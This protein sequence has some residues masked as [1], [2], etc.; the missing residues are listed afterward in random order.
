MY[1]NNNNRR[2][3]D[4][5]DF[6]AE[7]DRQAAMQSP[8]SSREV[9]STKH[10]AP[11]RQTKQRSR[12]SR[13]GEAASKRDA[14]ASKKMK[15]PISRVSRKKSG[16][17][18]GGGRSGPTNKKYTIYNTALFGALAVIMAIG[19]YVGVIFAVAPRVDTDDIYSMLS[20]R[21]I[22]YDS[23]GNEIENLYFDDG[24]RTVI[25][26]K[27]IPENMVNAVV[28][29]EDKKFWK[30]NGFNFIRMG[31]AVIESVFGGGQIS[32]TSTVTQQ[33]ARN[34]YLA[35]IKSQRSIS[36]KLS[37]MY[38]T[39]V[40]EKNLSKEEIMEAYLNTIYLGFNSYG[41][42]SAAQSYF[43][44][45][46]KDLDLL[47]CASL[48]ALPK[49]PDTYALV[50]Y[51]T[52]GSD[53]A[54]PVLKTDGSTS[55]VYNGELSKERRD[56]VLNIMEDEGFI[57]KEEHETALADDLQKHMKVSI[58]S[59]SS[60]TS[61]FTDFAI[62]QLI[63]DLVE[64]YG[65]SEAE[66]Q[67]MVYTG[68]LRIYTTMD[69]KMQQIVK[70]EFDEDR[71]FPDILY[72]RTNSSGDL[73]NHD[74]G[75]IM[76]YAYSHYFNKNNEFTLESG[77]YTN[78]EDGGITI[79][80]G[81]RLNIYETEVNGQPDVSI[82]FKGMYTKES[83]TFYFI[84]SG[85]LSIPQGYKTVNGDGDVVVSG[86]FFKDYPEFFKKDGDDLVVAAGNYSLKQKVIQPQGAMV[87]VENKTG[88]VK[89]MIGG[90]E[91]TGKQ[92]FNR[93]IS[94]RQPGSA[95]KPI[96]AYGPAIQMGYEYHRD[97]KTMR[98]DNS[99]GS[100]WGKYI[101]A[102]SVINDAAMTYGGRTWPRNWYGGYKGDM[103]LRT[104]VEQSAN[105]PA[106]KTYQ[107]IGPDYAA[108]MLKKNGVTTV[109][110]EG[111]VN[112]LNPAA[113]GLGG[114]ASG[115]SPLEMAAAYATFPN[116][117]VYNKPLAYT[118]VVDANNEVIMEKKSEGKQVYNEG[119]AWIMTD[120]L[121]TSVTRGIASG[122]RMYSQPSGGK[123]GTTSDNFDIWFCGFTPQY[124][125]AIWMGNDMNLELNSGSGETANMFSNIMDQI[126]KNLPRGS[127]KSM[128]SNVHNVNGEYYIKG[129]YS[130]VKMDNSSSNSSSSASQASDASSSVSNES[131]SESS[132]AAESSSSGS[133]H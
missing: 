50:Q 20:Q 89:A 29:I 114:M 31:G 102:G 1:N 125:A 133:G 81:K 75:E 38:C 64:E 2:R 4:I 112:D 9:E 62:D 118:K 121:R 39:I 104:A 34:V 105:I 65:V 58:A 106:V 56:L 41:V 115:I 119:V 73:L 129:T 61:Y 35:E 96:A 128:P 110:D 40:L 132:S 70:Q 91:I 48:A 107:Q 16:G 90:R 10:S 84:E 79:K 13:Q 63:D 28:A 131:S 52:V 86:D 25:D 32:G 43:T 7:F 85:A 87:I 108:S 93:A 21:S 94:P 27:E 111:E 18:G 71:N 95:V 66:A 3:D 19:I 11:R 77:E 88:H 45:D 14:S 23:E 130:N 74:S 117:G 83:G 76:L 33:L 44:K 60:G 26:Y 103:K 127:F 109:D 55:Y 22:M 80:A 12:A 68:G 6:F 97:G 47:E 49:S 98:L 82:E 30:H 54:L 36:R 37:E 72:A 100:D 57:T 42:E 92:L 53:N 126:C 123:T 67:T 120:I 51:S 5:D 17:A 69:S 8:S 124:S 101:T 116:G 122:A 46:A 15:S 24:N 59:S 78:N 113:L 99:D